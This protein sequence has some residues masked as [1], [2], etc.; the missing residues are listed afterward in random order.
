[1]IPPM[2]SLLSI[3]KYAVTTTHSNKLLQQ[4]HQAHDGRGQLQLGAVLRQT[5]WTVPTCAESFLKQ[6]CDLMVSM[7]T[8]FLPRLHCA[9]TW[10]AG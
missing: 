9:A 3:N 4:L 7:P 2:L 6:P 10:P 8:D 5:R 1:M